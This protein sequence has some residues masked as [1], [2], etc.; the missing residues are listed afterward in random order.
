MSNS[1]AGKLQSKAERF[2][3][4]DSLMKAFKSALARPS[5]RNRAVENANSFLERYDVRVPK[6]LQIEFRT[7]PSKNPLGLPGPDFMPFVIRL[8]NCRTYW[9]KKKD[10]IGFEQVTV[11]FGFEIRPIRVNPIG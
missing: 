7:V 9:V 4:D 2:A 8:F 10:G 3:V 11:C 6:G 5:L 1:P